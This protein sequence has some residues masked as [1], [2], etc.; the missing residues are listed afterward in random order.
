MKE[1][2]P[3]LDLPDD[4]LAAIEAARPS[5]RHRNCADWPAAADRALRIALSGPRPVSLLALSDIF[6]EEGWPCDPRTIK[7]RALELGLKAGQ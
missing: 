7:R 4:L 3:D 1:R 6:R 5:E 2:P